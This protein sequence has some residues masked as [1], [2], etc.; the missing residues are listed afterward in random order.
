MLYI[1]EGNNRLLKV[2]V[3]ITI[4]IIIIIFKDLFRK[5]MFELK[6]I[7][8]NTHKYCQCLFSLLPDENHL[9]INP[10]ICFSFVN[11]ALYLCYFDNFKTS[12]N[13]HN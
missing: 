13:I 7:F 3:I 4:I 10:R 6:K 9:Q 8:I 11:N 1:I 12:L 5:R 2:T